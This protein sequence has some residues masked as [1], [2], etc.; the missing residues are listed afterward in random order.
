VTAKC[1][2]PIN[3]SK[4]AAVAVPSVAKLAGNARET[5]DGKFTL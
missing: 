1:G 4:T 2:T 3:L 5:V